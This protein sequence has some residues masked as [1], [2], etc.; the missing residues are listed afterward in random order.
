[1]WQGRGGYK[2]FICEILS[3]ACCGQPDFSTQLS[4]P[5]RD[6]NLQRSEL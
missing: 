4:I 5:N 1:M 2:G 3:L 6:F